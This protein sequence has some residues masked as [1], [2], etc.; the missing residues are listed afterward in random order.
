MRN[1]GNFKQLKN[2]VG[3][4]E[5]YARYAD[6]FEFRRHTQRHLFDFGLYELP[7]EGHQD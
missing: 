3:T 4:S 1:G 2:F 7:V 5:Q 6:V